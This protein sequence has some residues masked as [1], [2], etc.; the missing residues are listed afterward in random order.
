MRMMASYSFIPKDDEIDLTENETAPEKTG[1]EKT[2]ETKKDPTGLS[3]QRKSRSLTGGIRICFAKSFPGSFRG[4]EE[5]LSIS[6]LVAGNAPTT[7]H[8]NGT[9]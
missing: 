3:G 2:V 5:F 1:E 8:S 7:N 6:I 4:D 9:P